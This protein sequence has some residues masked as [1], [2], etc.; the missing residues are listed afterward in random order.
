MTS[1]SVCIATF[2][3]PDRLALLLDDLDR[4]ALP[5]SE[6]I[7]I[8]NDHAR[9]GLDVVYPRQS[10]CAFTLRYAVVG[11]QNIAQARNRGIDLARGEWVAFVDDDERVTPDWLRLLASTVARYDADAVLGP[12][13]PV[14]PPTAPGWIQRGRFYDWA[15]LPTGSAVPP[16]RL[17]LGNALVR[18]ALLGGTARFD[19]AF[20]LTGGEDGDLLSR[21]A[22]DGARF[23]WCDEAVVQEPVEAERLS[24]RWLLRRALRGG[25][26]FARHTLNGRY[27]EP[28]SGV[29]AR[30][31]ARS[32][33]QLCIA[34]FLAVA[35]LPLGR[36][37][38]VFWLTRASA[39]LGKLSCF[40]GWHYREYAQT[41]A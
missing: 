21:L 38:A 30:L 33:S 9:S 19:P 8:D 32:S 7:V 15:R 12:V 29:R 13:V 5:P 11:E 14:V 41:E 22:R 6:V 24:L 26:D 37:H 25:Q 1:I 3:R 28:T 10:R 16:N 20:G 27:G 39:N 2:R 4:Q 23:V 40:W 34:L 31:F 17:R 18:R 36:H 35:C